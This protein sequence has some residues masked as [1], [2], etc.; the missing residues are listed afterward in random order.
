MLGVVI[1]FCFVL[2]A[3]KG[4]DIHSLMHCQGVQLQGQR[5]MHLAAD[6]MAV[7]KMAA[8]SQCK[9]YAVN[10][11]TEGVEVLAQDVGGWYLPIQYRTPVRA[12]HL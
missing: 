5:V 4:L 2:H 10:E 6:K 12:A 1:L 9:G 7:D 11:R 3:V 8:C